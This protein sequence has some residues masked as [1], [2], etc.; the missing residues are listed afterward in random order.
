MERM[1]K[2]ALRIV[3]PDW[4]YSKALEAADI[5]SLY[6]RRQALSTAFLTKS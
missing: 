4:P 6:E 5:D 2:R 1:Q 3:Y